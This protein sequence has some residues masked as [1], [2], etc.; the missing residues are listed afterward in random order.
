MTT[1]SAPAPT[2]WTFRLRRALLWL[3][4]LPIFNTEKWPGH[5]WGTRLIALAG[6][7]YFLY[8]KASTFPGYLKGVDRWTAGLMARGFSETAARS[9]G[10]LSVASSVL[11]ML[12]FL[13]YALAWA[14]RTRARV[15]AR[16]FMEVVFPFLVAFL[17]L[18]LTGAPQT[19]SRR[20]SPESPAFMAIL[21]AVNALMVGGFLITF[22][23][24]L[25]LRSAFSIMAEARTLI[26]SGFFRWMRHPIYTGNF[27]MLLGPLVLRFSATSAL[28]YVALVV[29]HYFRARLEERKL[30]EAYP[31]YE[32]YRRTTGMFLPKPGRL[33]AALA[34]GRS[35]ERPQS[36]GISQ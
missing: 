5:E 11:V 24:V 30:A 15:P 23:A 8:G 32:D 3:N 20:I 18:Y 19:L 12:V 17:P 7:A 21:L 25:N 13:G 1:L 34:A 27:I 28:I 36:A 29:G 31:E 33:F 6:A 10:V 26:R 22:L 9:V 16:G 14:T 4:Y 35:G 2:S